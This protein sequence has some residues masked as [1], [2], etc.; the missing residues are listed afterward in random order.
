MAAN[1]E[2]T[3]AVHPPPAQPLASR[4]LSANAPYSHGAHVHGVGAGDALA[5]P[6]LSPHCEGTAQMATTGNRIAEAAENL[7]NSAQESAD[8]TGHAASEALHKVEH[9]VAEAAGAIEVQ[10][11]QL[12][13]KVKQGA[14]RL[15]EK[16]RDAARPTGPGASVTKAQE[17]AALV[18][19]QQADAEEAAVR[20]AQ[21]ITDKMKI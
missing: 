14:H 6:T 13:E 7:K 20:K 21:V 8:K 16:V 12:G 15:A 9:K 19:K 17:D 3:S 1:A 11:E 4:A 2:R 18:A 5:L 10:A